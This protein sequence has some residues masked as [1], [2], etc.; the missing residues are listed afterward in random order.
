MDIRSQNTFQKT[1]QGK[2][3]FFTSFEKPWLCEMLKVSI[4]FAVDKFKHISVSCFLFSMVI[5]CLPF[6]LLVCQKCIVESLSCIRF[7]ATPWTAAL[8][9][10]LSFSI[11]KPKILSLKCF[12]RFGRSTCRCCT[13]V[14]FPFCI[15]AGRQVF[16]ISLFPNACYYV[17]FSRL[18]LGFF[19]SLAVYWF[20]NIAIN[21]L[22]CGHKSFFPGVFFINHF[23]GCEK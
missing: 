6:S 16:K 10:S 22:L 11:E 7:S 19:F 17:C 20:T 15:A 2:S 1:Y 9:A 14:F 18:V 4:I 5:V 13:Q 8:Q 3:A 23:I 21:C 12:H